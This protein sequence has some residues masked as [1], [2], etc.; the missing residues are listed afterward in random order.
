MDGLSH[1]SHLPPDRC[2]IGNESLMHFSSQAP[3]FILFNGVDDW[4]LADK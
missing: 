2:D 1:S 4:P 3:L